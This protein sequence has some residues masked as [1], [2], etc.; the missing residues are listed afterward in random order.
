MATKTSSGIANTD[1]MSKLSPVVC[2][3]FSLVH[4][5]YVRDEQ[6]V[7][8]LTAST[9]CWFWRV[10]LSFLAQLRTLPVLLL[11]SFSLV[12]P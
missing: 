5:L 3:A 6:L 1:D 10:L 12:V 2:L 11:F 4:K 8:G 9:L 7:K